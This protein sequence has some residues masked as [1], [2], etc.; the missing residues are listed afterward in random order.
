MALAQQAPPSS[1]TPAG[2]SVGPK[3]LQN[4]SL[5]GTVT[6]PADQQP[7]VQAAPRTRQPRP[8]AQVS[9][10]VQS[11]SRPATTSNAQS[12]PSLAAPPRRTEIASREPA[13]SRPERAPEPSTQAPPSPSASASLPKIDAGSSTASTLPAAS[14]PASPATFAPD[15][16]PVGTLA[17]EHRF[18]LLPWLL[19]AIALGAGGAFLFW[20]NRGREAFAGGPQID[21]FT[22]PAPA[23]AP[24]PAPTPP[25]AAPEPTSPAP[26]A[27]GFVSTRLR[28]WVELGFN[29]LRCILDD[30]RV[31][32]EFEI[33]LFNSGSA[34]ARAVL[35]E[36][37]IFNAGATQDQE[38]AAFFADPVGEGERIVAIPPLKRMGFK[39]QV[40]APRAQLQ[41]Y[42]L[43]GRQVFVPVIAF[44][45]LYGWSG[46]EGQTS[47]SYLLGR[48]TNGERMAPFRLDLGP[49]IFR[50]IA[51]RLLPT[52]VRR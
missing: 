23:V 40:T 34:P 49:R 28:P 45:V 25:A 24:R 19:A 4:F 21:A 14:A 27:P 33:E 20:R 38:I 16:A 1:D 46:G 3:E 48:D 7:A 32:I 17:P 37:S 44:N 47:V 43:A 15:P 2:D 50:G 35:A 52:G 12:A 18:S 30:E 13:N 5:N 29:P 26:T 41:A 22:G 42:A 6:H 10:S 39:T 9:S 8:P 51:A 11:S 31:T 36:A